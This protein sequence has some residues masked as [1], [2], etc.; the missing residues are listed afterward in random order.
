MTFNK[1]KWVIASVVL[2]FVFSGFFSGTGDIYFEVSKSIDIF[3]K[4]YKEISFNYVDEIQPDKFM[5][6]G[7]QGML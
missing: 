2:L 6:A 3:S 4:V 7:I 1:I 5:E